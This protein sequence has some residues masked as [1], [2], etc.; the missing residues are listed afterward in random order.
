MSEIVNRIR[1]IDD[2]WNTTGCSLEQIDEAQ[3]ALDLVFP[4]E[5]VEYVREF[6]CIDFF[7]TEW[8]GLNIEGDC[9]TVKATL[10]ERELNPDF[11][12]KMFVL[13]KA[14]IDGKIVAVDEKGKVYLVEYDKCTKIHDSILE[15]LERCIKRK[16]R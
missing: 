4:I 8:T 5:Y 6:G 15:Y 16:D 9:N 2:L 3:R 13:E 1:E 7:A 14:G 12:K 10:F 11:P